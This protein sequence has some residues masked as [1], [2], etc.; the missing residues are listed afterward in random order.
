MLRT[1]LQLQDPSNH[2]DLA[3]RQQW[4]SFTDVD[5]DPSAVVLNCRIAKGKIGPGCVLVNVVAPEVDLEGCILVKVSTTKPVKG[6]GGLLYN[7]VE[8]KGEELRCDAV[9]ADIFMPGGVHHKV[10]SDRSTDGGKAW[11]ETLPKNSFSFE[12][13]YKANQP[14]DVTQCTQEATFAHEAVGAKPWGK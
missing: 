10:Y 5:V 11:K 14:L 3:S 4:N 8:E 12:G 7:V 9:R 13:I 2:E 6:K 1:F